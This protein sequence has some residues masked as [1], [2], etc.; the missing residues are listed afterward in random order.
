[1]IIYRS[2]KE[3]KKPIR[4]PVVAIGNFDGVHVG[5]K[6][7]FKEIIQKAKDIG[8]T[9]VIYTFHP[10]PS[11]VI[12]PE[13][14]QPQ[15]NSIDER[16]TLIE[17]QGIDVTVVEN[18]N[19]DFSQQ[20]ATEFFQN[21]ILKKLK[22]KILYVGYN[23]YFGRGR[24]GTTATLK[25]LCQKHSIELN[26]MPA[27]KLKGEVISSSKI[28]EALRS[29]NVKKAA[30]FLGRYYF[31]QGITIK[32]V[33]RG[34]TLGIPTANIQTPA[35]ITPKMG[36]YSTWVEYKG[37]LYA[38][39]TNVG[40]APTFSEKKPH[41]IEAHIFDFKKNLYGESFIL[42]FVDRIRAIKKFSSSQEL[43]KQIKA[44][45]KTARAMLSVSSGAK[46]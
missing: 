5:H 37:K 14:C 39:V 12:R 2:S 23:F 34:K 6:E 21:I 25:K 44:D 16:L 19:R 20:S 17:N 29:G 36:V 38:S 18:F 27:F 15:I 30:Q 22:P 26:V 45:I 31:L 13:M 42:H 24:E 10:H 43:V 41:S 7:I 28:R 9:S 4:R 3:I 1:M 11:C 32:G 8:G 40:H 46:S 33:G 35:E